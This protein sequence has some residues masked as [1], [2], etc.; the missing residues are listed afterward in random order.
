[1]TDV[2]HFGDE[3]TNVRLNLVFV[4]LLAASFLEQRDRLGRL[5]AKDL[6]VGFV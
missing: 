4:R 1:M 5:I 2:L 6:R 3:R